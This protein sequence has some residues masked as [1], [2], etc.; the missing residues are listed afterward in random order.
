MRSAPLKRLDPVM[1]RLQ[2]DRIQPVHSVLSALH[3]RHSTDFAQHPE[4][5]RDDWLRHP[6]SH[7]NFDDGILQTIC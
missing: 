2:V 5:F 6:Q 4:M 3:H 7:H 1:Y